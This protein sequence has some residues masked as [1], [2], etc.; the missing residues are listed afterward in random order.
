MQFQTKIII[1]KNSEGT[2]FRSNDNPLRLPRLR[3]HNFLNENWMAI[4]PIRDRL[5]R[6]V[7]RAKG[8]WKS[9]PLQNRPE[10]SKIGMNLIIYE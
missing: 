10:M 5:F 8:V 2:I 3:T 1:M 9:H 6:Q 4:N 7:I